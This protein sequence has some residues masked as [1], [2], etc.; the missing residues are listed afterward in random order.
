MHL[1]VLH[2]AHHW[3]FCCTCMDY[4]TVA[5]HPTPPHSPPGRTDPR[6]TAG[7]HLWQHAAPC[8]TRTP[9]GKQS[10]QD[11][12]HVQHPPPTITLCA[13]AAGAT[14]HTSLFFVCA[15]AP[16]DGATGGRGCAAQGRGRQRWG[17]SARAGTGGLPKRGGASCGGAG[18]TIVKAGQAWSQQVIGTCVTTQSTLFLFLL[19]FSNTIFRPFTQQHVLTMRQHSIVQQHAT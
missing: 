15:W 5:S 11:R 19:H 16:H 14:A 8:C 4:P 12:H 17:K 9:A 1:V 2:L 13:A 3:F 18:G 7:R 6:C 10:M